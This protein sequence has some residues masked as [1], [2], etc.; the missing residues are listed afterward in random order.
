MISFY[1]NISADFADLQ[2][3]KAVTSQSYLIVCTRLL[4]VSPAEGV[5]PAGVPELQAAGLVPLLVGAGRYDGA[6]P[7]FGA[8]LI[9]A[10]AEK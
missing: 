4:E 8:R 10:G 6:A 7:A 5:G 2:A 9:R 1:W 3:F